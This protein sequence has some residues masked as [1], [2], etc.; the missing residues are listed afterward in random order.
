VANLVDQRFFGKEH[1]A[2]TI[3]DVLAPTL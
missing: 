3:A 1:S 2:T